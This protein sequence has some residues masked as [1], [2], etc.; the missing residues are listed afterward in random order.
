MKD[1]YW[2]IGY[3]FKYQNNS[4]GQG[5]F[6]LSRSENDVMIG[7]K[8]M[9]YLKEEAKKNL[10]DSKFIESLFITSISYLGHMTKNEFN[11]N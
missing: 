7:L 4:N 3:C 6:T 10:Q 1:H 9:E 8:S 11:N 2:L 5:S